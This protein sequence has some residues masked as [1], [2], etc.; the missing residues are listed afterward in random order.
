MPGQGSVQIVTSS[1]GYAVYLSCFSMFAANSLPVAV[2]A[3]AALAAMSA[4]VDASGQTTRTP[5]G[6][7]YLPFSPAPSSGGSSS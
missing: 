5:I 4:L 1:Y 2:G 3:S 7:E 6:K